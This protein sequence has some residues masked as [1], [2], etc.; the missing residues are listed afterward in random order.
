MSRLR[1]DMT[2]IERS[3]Q[4]RHAKKFCMTRAIWKGTNSFG[5]VNIP[6]ALYPATRRKE[7][8]FRLLRKPVDGVLVLEL[9][10]FADELADPGKLD[11]PKKTKV[12]KRETNMAKSL[13]D[14]M[15]S[16]W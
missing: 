4:R 13:I 10:H 11:V 5:R 12:G 1:L 14:S 8:K 16:K 3:I 15:S 9:M 2:R 7:F 6:I